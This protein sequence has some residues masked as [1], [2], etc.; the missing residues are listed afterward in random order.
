MHCNF[1]SVFH[2]LKLAKNFLVDYNSCAR[3]DKNALQIARLKLLEGGL[4]PRV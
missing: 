3:Q 1:S 2:F 4:A